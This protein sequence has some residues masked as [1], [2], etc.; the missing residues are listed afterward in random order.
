MADPSNQISRTAA[1]KSRRE[2]D[3]DTRVSKKPR[4]HY[5]AF[6]E[7]TDPFNQITTDARNTANTKFQQ[8]QIWRRVKELEESQDKFSYSVIEVRRLNSEVKKLRM[9][10]SKYRRSE[11]EVK[12]LNAKLRELEWSQKKEIERKT[13]VD[14]V[15]T[16]KDRVEAAKKNKMSFVELMEAARQE[17]TKA[18][19]CLRNAQK[20]WEVITIDGDDDD[21]G[22]GL[23]DSTQ[24]AAAQNQLP[25]ASSSTFFKAAAGELKALEDRVKA[26]K[27]FESSLFNKL[28]S[29]RQEVENAESCFIAAQQKQ[30]E[31]NIRVMDNN[32]QTG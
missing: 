14:R 16:A 20:Q 6:A 17:V 11:G 25:Y 2:Y 30:K 23:I 5:P 7:M 26:A 3:Q 13:L 27:E 12:R 24:P 22:D 21:D 32:E 10:Q 29:A 4:A 28:A 1:N 9:F 31:W 19:I 8:P 18:E 15:N